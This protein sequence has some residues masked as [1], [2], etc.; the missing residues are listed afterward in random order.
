MQKV[1]SCQ[2]L[3]FPVSFLLFFLGAPGAGQADCLARPRRSF[4]LAVP[5]VGAMNILTEKS[6]LI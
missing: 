3:F 6:L 1:S 5:L 4:F 2:S